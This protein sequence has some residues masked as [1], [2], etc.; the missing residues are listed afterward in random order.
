MPDAILTVLD[1]GNGCCAV[2]RDGDGAV[3]FDY[4]G[5]PEPRDF[6]RAVE[7]EAFDAAF[8]SHTHKDHCA[9]LTGHFGEDFP[10]EVIVMNRR[11][12]RRQSKTY[13][14]LI[15]AITVAKEG[16]RPPRLIHFNS[17]IREQCMERGG[18]SIRVLWPLSEHDHADA[19]PEWE[20]EHSSCGVV[21]IDQGDA[22]CV[23][24]PGDLDIRGMRA[25]AERDPNALRAQALV[26]PHHGGD[27]GTDNYLFAKTLTSLVEP[28]MVV[29]SQARGAHGR[30]RPEILKGI[31]A[32]APDVYVACTQLSTDCDKR[33][34]HE[35]DPR[36]EIDLPAAGIRT[37]R[38]ACCAGP[39]QIAI[40]AGS[41]SFLGMES[42]LGFVGGQVENAMC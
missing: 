30:P 40:E 16:P 41:V 25:I 4:A 37:S 8:I 36:S 15:K 33:D 28:S 35:K 22:R 39:V 19:S 6:F 18:L 3:L 13:K 5:G 17:D 24:L 11:R 20:D 27:S 7:I 42:H 14:R 38:G 26:F 2:L 23:L 29:F 32:A 34:L 10:I 9:G 31:R 1:V 21:R 12:S